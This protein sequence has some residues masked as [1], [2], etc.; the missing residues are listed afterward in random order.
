MLARS[1]S[2]AD[3]IVVPRREVNGEVPGEPYPFAA[4]LVEGPRAFRPQELVAMAVSVGASRA[5]VS[6]DAR[7]AA[8][9]V[10]DALARGDLLAFRRAAPST[11]DP[12]PGSVQVVGSFTVVTEAR[13][14]GA[15]PNGWDA[16][17][18][19]A[20]DW[21]APPPRVSR[22]ARRTIVVFDV[23]A[24]RVSISTT[25]FGSARPSDP[26]E[27]DGTLG[28][29]EERHRQLAQSW[30]TTARLGQIAREARIALALDLPGGISPAEIQ[31]R[32]A[33]QVGAIRDYVTARHQNEQEIT[34]DRL[35]DRRPRFG[36]VTRR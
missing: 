6:S 34:L 13:D 10:R 7:L 36:G 29:H 25:Y 12:A 1:W 5:V 22:A 28:R 27:V 16:Q 14:S 35:P 24:T 18:S 33:R 17:T 4:R 9:H 20:L 21:S 19:Y 23:V 2:I 26:H 11:P 8:R 15:N 3:V 31:R 30:W 32:M